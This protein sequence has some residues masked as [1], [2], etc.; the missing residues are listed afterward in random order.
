ME[1]NRRGYHHP[2]NQHHDHNRNAQGR[3]EPNSGGHRHM[4][5]PTN[6]GGHTHD[7]MHTREHQRNVESLR[8]AHAGRGQHDH[9][10]ILHETHKL[11]QTGNYN[12]HGNSIH[13]EAHHHRM[14][15]DKAGGAANLHIGDTGKELD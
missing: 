14:G 13:G 2:N 7:M 6:H 11:H 12:E 15:S 1:D 8:N 9:E 3:M 5:E 10:K 4:S